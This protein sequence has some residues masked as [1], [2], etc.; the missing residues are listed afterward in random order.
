[1]I[2]S[3]SIPVRWLKFGKR[4]ME[5]RNVKRKR[6]IIY[7]TEGEKLKAEAERGEKGRP[8]IGSSRLSDEADKILKGRG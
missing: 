7:R 5:D 2:E 1:M 6:I 3:E 8:K 4:W